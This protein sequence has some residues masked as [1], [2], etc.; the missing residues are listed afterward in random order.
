MLSAAYF[1]LTGIFAHRKLLWTDEI[2][3]MAIASQPDPWRVLALLVDGPD[4][5]PPLSHLLTHASL[6]LLGPSHL[7]V[8]L[9]EAVGYWLAIVCTY[10]YVRRHAD[11]SIACGAAVLL[12]A[13]DAFAYAFEARPYGLL[14]GF[15]AL[16]LFCWQR[17][18]DGGRLWAAGVPL[19]LFAA[20]S[21]H[22]Y[23]LLA[24]LPLL[25]AE[26]V[27]WLRDRDFRPGMATLIA[28]GIG[29][30][31]LL[32]P[33]ARQAT[34]FRG[35][36]PPPANPGSYVSSAYA[37][38]GGVILALLVIAVLA[39]FLAAAVRE[40]PDRDVASET[41]A[42]TAALVPAAAFVLGQLS[43]G[44]SAARYAI[45]TSVGVALAAGLAVGYLARF[46][47]A[48]G[49]LFLAAATVAAGVNVLTLKHDLPERSMIRE[50]EGRYGLL[51]IEAGRLE[52]LPVVVGDIHTFLPLHHYASAALTE[53]L[54]YVTSQNPMASRILTKLTA[55]RPY[56]IHDVATLLQRHRDFYYYEYGERTPLLAL[57]A[58]S[59]V[60]GDSGLN[61][62]RDLFPR[63]GY[64]Y[65]LQCQNRP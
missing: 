53:R 23:G 26:L 14:G 50:G 13:M 45:F 29:S 33:F 47:P 19:S 8:R 41:A 44:Q 63:P 39:A 58:R 10:H 61:D 46:A 31:A 22:W 40:R 21:T 55:A 20:V 34:A 38:A 4:T 62:L 43:G 18:S 9:P 49:P 16:A 30:T 59:C 25:A 42:V 57:L 3:T 5:L 64:L 32:L 56:R 54:V 12:L 15:S 52:P 11:A 2:V 35:M 51:N 27:R 36:I 7:A 65:R 28:I 6:S 1:A 37:I 17:S 48:A 24:A 60:I